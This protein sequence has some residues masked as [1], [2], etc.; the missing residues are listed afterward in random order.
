MHCTY[1]K[2]NH[3]LNSVLIN[4]QIEDGEKKGSDRFE[5]SFKSKE[6]DLGGVTERA[7]ITV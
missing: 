3:K 1:G 7:P 2:Q 5:V 6:L 4:A